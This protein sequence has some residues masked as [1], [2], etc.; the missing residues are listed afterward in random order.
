[1]CAVSCPLSTL[2]VPVL[3][4][5]TSFTPLIILLLWKFQTKFKTPIYSSYFDLLPELSINHGFNIIKSH[6]S[7]W[8]VNSLCRFNAHWP[9]FKQPLWSLGWLGTP[10][11]QV[12]T[13]YICQTV[14]HWSLVAWTPSCPNNNCN[15]ENCQFSTLCKLFCCWKRPTFWTKP[16]PHLSV[17]R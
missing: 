17:S 14:K 3:W 1:M 8:L 2:R 5:C 11:W 16:F 6:W 10:T 12:F 9:G 13:T 7:G 15:C 4:N